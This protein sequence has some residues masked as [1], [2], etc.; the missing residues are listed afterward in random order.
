[1]TDRSGKEIQNW[2]DLSNF[3]GYSD[4]IFS[5]KLSLVRFLGQLQRFRKSPMFID[6]KITSVYL[7]QEIRK[8]KAGE[9]FVVDITKISSIKEQA[10]IVGDVMKSIDE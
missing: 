10:F 4:F 8:L 3:I 1:M 2:K 6:K 5:H 7:G 9:I